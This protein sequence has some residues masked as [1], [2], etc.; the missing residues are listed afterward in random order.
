MDFNLEL[1]RRLSIIENWLIENNIGT[2]TEKRLNISKDMFW[3]VITHCIDENDIIYMKNKLKEKPFTICEGNI[4][5]TI[6]EYF[7]ENNKYVAFF[8]DIAEI[9]PIGLNTS[10]NACCGKFELFYR[11]LRPESLQPKKGDIMDNGEICEIKGKTIEGGVR[12]SDTELTG[13]EYKRICSKIF[14]Q[15]ITGNIVK[16][17]GLSGENAYEI[18]KKQYCEHYK[19]EF[20][21]DIN[22]SKKLIKN[23]FDEN[24][25]AIMDDEIETIFEHNDWN[26][27]KMNRII[28]K[29]MFNKYKIQKGFNKMVVFGDGTNVKI[30]ST[31]NDLDKIIII[32]DYF[33][34]NQAINVG[35]YII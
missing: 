20:G 8:R 22:S 23:Y 10:P 4:W 30:L 26:Q 3:L 29:K 15:H 6:T 12:I 14:E 17:G 5:E 1:H 16:K 2:T 31:D 28:L 18:E 35:W 27:D 21:K 7:N 24:G 9:T 33:R 13:K 19:I 25:W 32:A 11:L 34:I